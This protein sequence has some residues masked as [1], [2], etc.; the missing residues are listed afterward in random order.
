VQTERTLSVPVLDAAVLDDLA[1]LDASL[2]ADVVDSF[3]SDVPQR[4]AALRRHI[5]AADA[6]AASRAAHALK[7]SALAVGAVALKDVCV[8]IELDAD[9]GDFAALTSHALAL[10]PVFAILK[11]ALNQWR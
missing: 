1:A 10:D 2:V 6:P 9:R 11:D 4:I 7:G 8:A 3:L 5:A